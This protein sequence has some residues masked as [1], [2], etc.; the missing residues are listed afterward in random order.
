[1]YSD[2]RAYVNG[3]VKICNTGRNRYCTIS[4]PVYRD[5][6]IKRKLILY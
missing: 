6:K 3:E 2:K 1:M 4:C 5:L